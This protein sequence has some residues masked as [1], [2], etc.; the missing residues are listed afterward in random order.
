[1]PAGDGHRIDRLLPQLGRKLRQ[2]GLGQPAQIVGRDDLVE[3][4]RPR[5]RRPI[6]ADL[7]IGAAEMRRHRSMRRSDGHVHPH[8]MKTRR[9]VAG[10]HGSSQK[11]FAPLQRKLLILVD[12]RGLMSAFGISYSSFPELSKP[13][14]KHH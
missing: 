5:R 10:Q 12:C 9:L 8:I 6:I 13:S 11:G 3:Q 4:R 1:M 7:R 14:Q 2:D